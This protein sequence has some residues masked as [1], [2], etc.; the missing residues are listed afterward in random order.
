MISGINLNEVVSFTA[1]NDKDN[2]T[3]WKLGVIPSL[4]FSK[5]TANINNSE[6]AYKLLQLTIKGWENFGDIKYETKKESVF[7]Q[8]M[9]IVPIELIQRIPMPIMTEISKEVIRISRL[10][11]EEQKN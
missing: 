4:L 8:D 10:T 6:S 5:L 9:E 1:K 3:I 11:E 7:G 2:P